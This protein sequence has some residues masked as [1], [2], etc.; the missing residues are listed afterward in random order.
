MR[1]ARRD[2]DPRIKQRMNGKKKKK[3]EGGGGEESIGRVMTSNEK[4]KEK[5]T[6]LCP[7]TREPEIHPYKLLY[8][9]I[10]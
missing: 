9:V 2:G 7:E 8:L 6:N 5:T 1:S 10:L 3:G 4:K